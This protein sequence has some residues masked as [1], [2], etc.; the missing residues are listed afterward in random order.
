M[1]YTKQ[2][3]KKSLCYQYPRLTI[4]IC[5]LSLDADRG[6]GPATVE[7]TSSYHTVNVHA[8]FQQSL[9]GAVVSVPSSQVKR[10]VQASVAGHEVGVSAHQHAHH[11]HGKTTITLSATKLQKKQGDFLNGT[12]VGKLQI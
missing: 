5:N 7:V 2:A 10:S 6:R 9:G 4:C 3:H 12:F 1:P 11:L 8:G